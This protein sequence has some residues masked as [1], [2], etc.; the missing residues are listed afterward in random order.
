MYEV[1]YKCFYRDQWYW[2]TSHDS[3]EAAVS[4]AAGLNQNS[5][6]AVAVTV[7]G[8]AVWVAPQTRAVGVGVPVMAGALPYLD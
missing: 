7:N 6:R 1:Y 8:A 5:G 4:R 3:P 2:D